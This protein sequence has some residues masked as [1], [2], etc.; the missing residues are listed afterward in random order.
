MPS[1]CRAARLLKRKAP[2][3]PKQCLKCS[4]CSLWAHSFVNFSG[5]PGEIERAGGINAV[6]DRLRLDGVTQEQPVSSLS[7]GE[8]AGRLETI[9]DWK[10][11][12]FC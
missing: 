10:F 4:L 6:L 9:G 1:T 5:T 8:K 11:A 3:S 7:G 2:N 12:S